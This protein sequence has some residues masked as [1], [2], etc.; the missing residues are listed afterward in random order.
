MAGIDYDEAMVGTVEVSDKDAMDLDALTA[1]FEAN[2]EGFEGPIEYSKFKGGQSNPTYRIDTPSRAYVLRR[3]PFGKL[4][5]SAHA[6]D[7][8]YTAMSALGPTGFPV[9]KT[10]GLCEDPDVIGSK[11]FVMGLA[12]GRN[13][14]NGA[15]PGIEPEERRAIYNSMIDTMADLHLKDPEAIGLGD[16]GKSMDYC[17][18]Q[19]ARWSKQ[20]KLSETEHMEKMERLIEWL[21]QTIPPQHESSVV[22]GDYRLDNLIFEKNTPNVLAVLDWELSTLGDPIAD[23]SYL[24][25]NWQ[26]ESDG[27]AGLGG[28]GL[29][30]L[31][32]PTQQEAVDRYVA[33][34]G[35]PV[36]PMDWYF[37]YNLFRLAGIIQGIK[38]RVI[39][40]TASSAH[41]KQ[42]SERVGPLVDRAYE[43]AQKAGMD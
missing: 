43:F 37:S 29:E 14:W 38:K 39:D 6:V 32:I 5:P 8:E 41:A 17:A 27:R 31:G 24:M 11:F 28:K 4:L 19:I 34:T 7:R 10:Y 16:Y 42:M 3:Q 20:Y 9:P 15:L 18:R 25:L 26:N 22:H 2:V 1:W 23:F 12:D 33:R 30:A 40:G 36:P 21:P 13:L 35:Y